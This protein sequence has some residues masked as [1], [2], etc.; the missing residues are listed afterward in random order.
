MR[1]VVWSN[2]EVW[3][4]GCRTQFKLKPH[5]EVVLEHEFTHGNQS[6]SQSGTSGGRIPAHSRPAH[7][8]A[9][10][11]KSA[12]SISSSS[13][14]AK[15][16]GGGLGLDFLK[17]RGFAR[18]TAS[19]ISTAGTRGLLRGTAS[20]QHADTDLHAFAHI[21]PSVAVAPGPTDAIDL[22]QDDD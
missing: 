8:A 21:R 14:K 1:F 12:T 18:P 20:S 19:L 4:V 3:L 7:T 17:E 13:H 6:S 11:T 5:T 2:V 16:H 10:S 9:A 22:T 15:T